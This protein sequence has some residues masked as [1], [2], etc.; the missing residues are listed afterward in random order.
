MA[1]ALEKV[2][3]GFNRT[4][5]KMSKGITDM[6]AEVMNELENEKKKNA[7]ERRRIGGMLAISFL[8]ISV[9]LFYLIVDRY[10]R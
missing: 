1:G 4:E 6:M 5:E 10:T 3:R 2:E 7:A 8:L 9:Q